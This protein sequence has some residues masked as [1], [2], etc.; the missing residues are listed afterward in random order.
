MGAVLP[1][2]FRI[3]GGVK[4]LLPE[5]HSGALDL[6][7]GRRAL[8]RMNSKRTKGREEKRQAM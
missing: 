6:R 5:N 1:S 2:P 7:G 4:K 3:I 8:D